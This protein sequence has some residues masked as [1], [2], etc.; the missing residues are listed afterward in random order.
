MDLDR[1]FA[2]KD[3]S[4]SEDE[5]KIAEKSISA[6]I[7]DAEDLERLADELI[8]GQW[9]SESIRQ[10]KGGKPRAS[11]DNAAVPMIARDARAFGKEAEHAP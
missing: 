2:R 9:F 5:R 6:G 7:T 11:D 3:V 8:I 4:L 1:I 10:A